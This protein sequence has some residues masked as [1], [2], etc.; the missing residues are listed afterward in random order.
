MGVRALAISPELGWWGWM[1]VLLVAAGP[2]IGWAGD[3][4]SLAQI[5][6]T[7]Q[8]RDQNLPGGPISMW[9]FSAEALQAYHI[10]TLGQL[11][12][13]IPNVNLDSGSVFAG[14]NTILAASIR[15]IG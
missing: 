14:S 12:G 11:S 8:E 7:A 13:L 15:G 2:G 10:N 4:D 1:T 9:G 3:T 6:G 5:V